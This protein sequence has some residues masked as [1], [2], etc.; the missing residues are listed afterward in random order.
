MYSPHFFYPF[1]CQKT[2]RC[3][4]FSAIMSNAAM[5]IGVQLKGLFCDNS[6]VTLQG[7]CG[8]RTK[9]PQR[10]RHLTEAAETK[11]QVPRTNTDGNRIVPVC[12]K[13]PWT[14][15]G[16]QNKLVL[17]ANID[18]W[19]LCNSWYRPTTTTLRATT[20]HTR[21]RTPKA[22]SLR[23]AAPLAT[24]LVRLDLGLL[25]PSDNRAASLPL[26]PCP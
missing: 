11:R 23:K 26:L 2:I 15:R 24:A 14:S 3:F 6:K 18:S 9:V 7:L 16:S 22:L 1:I 12:E 17:S 8:G 19:V 5:N 13:G 10:E 21:A 20:T 4:H 25:F